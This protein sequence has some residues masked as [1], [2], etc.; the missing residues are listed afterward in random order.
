MSCNGIF[1]WFYFIS[2]TLFAQP[3]L[4]DKLEC[5]MGLAVSSLSHVRVRFMLAV[6]GVSPLM[7]RGL[8]PR[9][10]PTTEED[11]PELV[12]SEAFLG[13]LARLAGPL[14]VLGLTSA[15]I[16]WKE[17]Q[18]YTLGCSLGFVHINI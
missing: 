15:R 5:E 10:A 11:P 2:S 13:L 4:L 12:C 17:L 1:I 18:G 9:S 14:L 16:K 8:A 3:I 6:Q 7:Y